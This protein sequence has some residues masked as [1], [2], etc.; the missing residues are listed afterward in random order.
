[1][2]QT[3][4]NYRVFWLCMQKCISTFDLCQLDLLAEVLIGGHCYLFF[5]FCTWSFIKPFTHY[6]V[7]KSWF[8]SPIHYPALDWELCCSTIVFNDSFSL[9]QLVSLNFLLY[10]CM[11]C[12]NFCL[13]TAH[14][15][16][17]NWGGLLPYF[18]P[19]SESNTLGTYQDWP[20]DLH[21]VLRCQVR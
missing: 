2:A 14:F 18:T 5:F 4:C 21:A 8:W 17:D 15:M 16:V 10:H 11:K 7:S 12:I 20:V 19:S 6:S 13:S 3:R 1:M 9:S